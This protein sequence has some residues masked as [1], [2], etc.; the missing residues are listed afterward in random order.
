MKSQLIGIF[1]L[2]L[3]LAITSQIAPAQTRLSAPPGWT[4]SQSG[5]NTLWTRGASKIKLSAPTK[6]PGVAAFFQAQVA[7]DASYRGPLRSKGEIRPTS[8]GGYS[9]IYTFANAVV[10]YGAFKRSD[11][12][13]F[14]A[15]SSPNIKT[16]QSDLPALKNIAAQIQRSSATQP[17]PTTTTTKSGAASTKIEYQGVPGKQYI[18]LS[19][20]VGIYL[21]ENYTTGVGGMTVIEYDPVLLLRDGTAYEDFDVPPTELNIASFKKARPRRVGRWTKTAKGFSVRFNGEKSSSELKASFKVKPAAAGQKLTGEYETIGGGGNTALGGN[22]MVAYS[23]SYFF[24]RNGRFSGERGGGSSVAGNDSQG[25]VAVAS[26]SKN[27]GTYSLSG[28]TL[29]LKYNDGR[30]ARRLFYFYPDKGS[31]GKPVIGIGSSAYI[32]E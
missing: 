32:P 26:R 29:R 16:L 2:A 30:V 11:G 25:S 28:Y 18:A 27:A 23:N 4:Q 12:T 1:P 14:L 22:V 5:S 9:T 3:G 6:T 7:K 10:A 31:K 19:Q 15:L 21:N 8:N 17:R 24:D 20:I 13:R